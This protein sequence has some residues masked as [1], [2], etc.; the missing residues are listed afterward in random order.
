MLTVEP[1]A[2]PAAEGDE[3]DIAA[4]QETATNATM[5]NQSSPASADPT[6]SSKCKSA[7]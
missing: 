7:E 4:S 2:S 6:H 3:T 1:T 5:T